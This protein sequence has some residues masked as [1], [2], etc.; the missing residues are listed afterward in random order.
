MLRIAAGDCALH[1]PLAVAPRCVQDATTQEGERTLP[2]PPPG[3]AAGNLRDKAHVALAQLPRRHAQVWQHLARAALLGIVEPPVRQRAAR[4]KGPCA[5]RLVDATEAEA[6]RLAAQAQLDL[7]VALLGPPAQPPL[8][9]RH[10]RRDVRDPP[11]VKVERVE[12][13]APLPRP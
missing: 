4:L 11:R 5:A 13:A 3:A 9:G 6:V 1:A 10:R 12:A 2:C 8:V 7:A